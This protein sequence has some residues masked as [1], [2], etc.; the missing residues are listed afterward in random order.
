MRDIIEN[1]PKV[2]E[3][4]PYVKELETKIEKV[5]FKEN[6]C[7]VKLERT[8]FFP[9]EGGQYADTGTLQVL[10][11]GSGNIF[12]VVNGMLLE[13]EVYEELD[14]AAVSRDNVICEG[15]PV[16]CK[17]DWDKRFSRMQNHTGEH[18]LTGVIHNHY[19]FDNVGFHLSDDSPVTMDLN[20][21]ITLE[22]VRKM[23]RIANE[24]VFKNLKVQAIYPEKSELGGID[25]RSKKEIDAQV[26]LIR[27]GGEIGESE[28]GE[29]VSGSSLRSDGALDMCACCAPHVDRTGEVGIIKVVSFENYKGGVRLGILCGRRAVDY[30]IN[31]GEVVGNITGLMSSN[32]NNVTENIENLQS[33]MAILKEKNAV[34][35][36]DKIESVIG[37]IETNIVFFDFEV[38][39]IGLKNAYNSMSEKH[40]GFVGVFVGNDSDGYR[41][42]AGNKEGGSRELAVKMREVLDAKGGGS[43]EMIQGKVNAGR[44]KIR[45]FFERI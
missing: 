29:S 40:S 44:D 38:D 18:I 20:G 28:A 14:G 34:L 1:N 2:Y 27:I 23:E 26:R 9:E 37:S 39:A 7:Y 42:N 36:A 21:V 4:E 10:D 8:I 16:L 31:L 30:L 33:E 11:D 45:E 15:A 25:Y 41:F 22:E 35:L 19:G 17:L 5:I 3:D 32:I 6:K 43:D 13:G 24:A 12:N